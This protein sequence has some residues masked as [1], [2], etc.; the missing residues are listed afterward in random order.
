M[1]THHQKLEP[2]WLSSIRESLRSVWYFPKCTYKV[3]TGPKHPLAIMW[4]FSPC[5]LKF[6]S[7]IGAFFP[8]LN[9]QICF[10]SLFHFADGAS[11]SVPSPVWCRGIAL[12]HHRQQ[13]ALRWTHTSPT[14]TTLSFLP[15]PLRQM[16]GARTT[17]HEC[18]NILSSLRDP[19]QGFLFNL[20]L[21][22][23]A[24]TKEKNS[25][26]FFCLTVGIALPLYS[27]NIVQL[28]LAYSENV[29]DAVLNHKTMG[30]CLEEC[31]N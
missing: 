8:L 3:V 29:A 27:Q 17:Y 2:L 11:F 25:L 12:W 18:T 16:W 1:T 31:T 15:H 22:R 7:E 23:C 20:G 26:F 5:K 30:A 21:C 10:Q 13:K 9:I 28:V 14:T 19:Q 4:F 6:V 24:E